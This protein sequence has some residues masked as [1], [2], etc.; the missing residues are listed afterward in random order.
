[1]RIRYCREHLR[2]SLVLTMTL[3]MLLGF[4][5]GSRLAEAGVLEVAGVLMAFWIACGVGYS[6]I[7]MRYKLTDGAE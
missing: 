4:W 5:M 2:E 3:F 6:R 1:M 7:D